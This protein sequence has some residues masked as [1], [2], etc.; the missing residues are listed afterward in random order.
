[1]RADTAPLTHGAQNFRRQKHGRKT[2]IEED[3]NAR[4]ERLRSEE[5][6]PQHLNTIEYG[7]LGVPGL[8]ESELFSEAQTNAL[9]L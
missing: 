7:R 1:M 5:R 4:V 8:G 9:A 3:S 2:S 6:P